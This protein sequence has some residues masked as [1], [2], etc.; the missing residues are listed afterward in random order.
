MFQDL[1]NQSTI[2]EPDAS[3]SGK[4]SIENQPKTFHIPQKNLEK[5]RE[6]FCLLGMING[7]SYTTT[8]LKTVYIVSFVKTPTIIT[9]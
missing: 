8:K 9:C 4:Q 7:P 3:R 6:V 2:F 1:K 5:K